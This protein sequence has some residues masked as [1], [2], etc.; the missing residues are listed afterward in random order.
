M[1]EQ[2]E[3]SVQS[4]LDHRLTPPWGCE[5]AGTLLASRRVGFTNSVRVSLQPHFLR[6]STSDPGGILEQECLKGAP[7]EAMPY[8]H[9]RLLVAIRSENRLACEREGCMLPTCILRFRDAH[10]RC[11]RAESS[12]TPSDSMVQF[13][14]DRDSLEDTVLIWGAIKTSY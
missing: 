7:P 1:Y 3:L 13:S 9:P 8:L 5:T 2:V 11:L 12:C 4:R 10:G 14:F 6:F